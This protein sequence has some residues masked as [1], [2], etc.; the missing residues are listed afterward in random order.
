[1]SH[2]HPLPTRKR[3]HENRYRSVSLFSRVSPRVGFNLRTLLSVLLL[4]LSCSCL[5][6]PVSAAE[7]HGDRPA[8]LLDDDLAWTGSSLYIDLSPPPIPARLMPPVHSDNDATRTLSAPPS[9]RSLSTDPDG[10]DTDFTIPTA[11]D[12]GLS[13]NFTNSCANFLSRLRTSDD[14]NNC[15]PFSLLLQTSSGFFDA[16]R[17]T[18]RIT[19]TLDATCGVNAEQCRSILDG[20]A[21]ELLSET[22]CKTDYEDDN[23][24]VL[25]AYNGLIAYMPDYQASC[26]HDS[27]GN[28]CFADAVS[29][30]SSPGDAYPYYLPLGQELPGGSRPTCNSCLQQVMSVFAYYGNNVTQPISKT[31]TTAAQQISVACGSTFVN[32]TA[33]PLKGVAASS[34]SASLTPTITLILMFVLYIF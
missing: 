33:A 12:T 13:N 11:F 30:S 6:A 24:L 7:A 27:E 20:F 9:K 32:V 26:L 18:L 16:S 3:Q 1:M 5:A 28:Y 4:F 29:N 34:T 21:L 22:A 10:A 8:L 14:F 23:P 31:Y 17:S 19:Q 25:Q 15:N 2:H